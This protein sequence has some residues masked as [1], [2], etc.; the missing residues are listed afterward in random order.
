[1][2]VGQPLYWLLFPSTLVYVLYL[3]SHWPT[4]SPSYHPR[5]LHTLLTQYHG[6]QFRKLLQ[7]GTDTSPCL[8]YP[9]PHPGAWTVYFCLRY[10]LLFFPTKMKP[11]NPFRRSHFD[12]LSL[13]ILSSVSWHWPRVLAFDLLLVSF[14]SNG[15]CTVRRGN[16]LSSSLWGPHIW[17]PNK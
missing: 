12:Y 2:F 5:L 16:L 17:S 1:M 10:Q 14:S 8:K 6:S 7:P 4:P 9:S 3:F 15:M 13:G 11:I